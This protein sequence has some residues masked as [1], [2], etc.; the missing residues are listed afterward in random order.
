MDWLGALVSKEP[1]QP[2][3][4]IG[5]C[6]EGRVFVV[7]VGRPCTIT[8]RRA[9]TTIRLLAVDL[10]IGARARV[11][12]TPKGSAGAPVD[13]PLRGSMRRTPRLTVLEAGAE[14][15]LTCEVPAG[16]E[17]CRFTLVNAPA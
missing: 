15:V 10:V 12:L 11:R 4:L 5:P 9:D 3:D 17:P 14:L 8:V 1:V 7:A 6:V 13:V 16:L 2:R